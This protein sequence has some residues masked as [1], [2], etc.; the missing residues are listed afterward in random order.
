[1]NMEPQR[2]MPPGGP[3]RHSGKRWTLGS[4]APSIRSNHAIWR[5]RGMRSAE[6]TGRP[7]ARAGPVSYD[8]PAASDRP[9]GRMGLW[10]VLDRSCIM[11]PRHPI[12]PSGLVGDGRAGPV[13]YDRA[14]EDDRPTRQ[15]LWHAVEP[16]H[17]CVSRHP[18]GPGGGGPMPRAGPMSYD[19][20]AAPDRPGCRRAMACD[21]PVPSD[22]AA[23]SGW[24]GA[25]DRPMASDR[26]SNQ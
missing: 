21:G 12:G 7:M 9:R 3:G 19:R 25:Y 13:L 24:P 1:M 8:R 16:S 2:P 4:E 18:I 23:T 20:A 15:G 22:C 14:A 6:G 5:R 10:G 11:I 17:T 26:A